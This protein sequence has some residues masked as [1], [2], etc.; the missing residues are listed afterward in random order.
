[1]STTSGLA[2]IIGNPTPRIDGPLKTSGK[3]EYAADFHFD[4]MV[5]AMPVCATIAKGSITNL[6]TAE[7]AKMTGVVAIY[8]R[9]NLGKRR[10][11]A[12]SFSACE[13][14]TKNARAIPWDNA[15]LRAAERS[16]GE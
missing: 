14:A 8:H 15:D 4:R 10:S 5:H 9:A 7:A 16:A 3:A 12:A 11:I 1:M 2:S 6:D 13:S